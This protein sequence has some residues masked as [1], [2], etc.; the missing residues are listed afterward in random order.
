MV[1]VNVNRIIADAAARLHAVGISAGEAEAELILCDLLDC[2]RL[3]L[4]LD[5]IR[6][7]DDPLLEKFHA[8]VEKRL[9]RYPLQYI[10]GSAWFYGRKFIVNEAVMVP[11]PETELLL[12]A[13]LRAARFCASR[14]VRLLDIG[15]GSGVVAL[16]A[17]LENSTLDVT[18][19]DISESALQVARTNAARLGIEDKIRFFCSDLF[20]SIPAGETFDIIASNPPYIRDDEYNGLEPEVK[21]DPPVARARGLD[22]IERLITDAPRYL[23]RPGFLMFEISFD[24]TA[25]ISELI[26]ADGRYAEYTVLKD[27]SNLDRVMICKVL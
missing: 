5:G 8:I 1:P 11:C 14:P 15:V 21:A 18:A 2:D 25:A 23:A 12:D 20:A 27:L 9:T 17:K 10:L 19:G 13:V 16:S 3:Q 22:V 7:I 6:R 24:Q 4:Y 26:R